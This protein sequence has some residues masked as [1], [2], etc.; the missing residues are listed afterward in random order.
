MGRPTGLRLGAGDILPRKHTE[1][2]VVPSALWCILRASDA[3]EVQRTR[4]TRACTEPYRGHLPECG[5]PSGNINNRKIGG[6]NQC[7]QG[8]NHDRCLDTAHRTHHWRSGVSVHSHPT[9]NRWFSKNDVRT[10]VLTVT[11]S[12][13]ASGPVHDWYTFVLSY[14]A[15]LVETYLKKF[16]VHPGQVVL[17]PFCGT[18]TT[19]VVA[20]GAGIPSIGIE[21]NPMAFFAS[22]VKVDWDISS[23]TLII[24]ARRIAKLAGV[25]LNGVGLGMGS[26]LPLFEASLEPVQSLSTF[27]AVEWQL[28]PE[29]AISPF[30]LHKLLVLRELLMQERSEDVHRHEL[31][32]LARTAVAVSNLKFGP[33][34]GLGKI[35]SDAPVV[36]FWLSAV[37]QMARDLNS[38]NCDNNVPSSVISG[39]A[40]NLHVLLG[41]HKINAIITSPPYP[42]EKDYTR[43]TR[44]ESVLLG[45]IQNRRELRSVKESLL[46]SNTRGVFKHDTD[47][48]IPLSIPDVDDLARVI[49]ARR[50]EL[51]KTSGFERLYS[52]LTRLYFGGMYRHLQELRAFL[53]PNARLAY[54]VGDQA[55]YFQVLIHTGQVVAK[56]AET[57][58]YQLESIDLF[59]A[60]AAT[61][62]RQPLR[63]EVVVLRWPG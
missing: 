11:P 27:S 20:K 32:A 61:A 23:D 62:T 58:G 28:L 57:L 25:R 17:D 55:S 34:V 36:E 30:P 43:T 1:R 33:E 10:M 2:L 6:A 12:A 22:S 7:P 41:G 24:H 38:S 9:E 59:R 44:L 35:K 15:D 52:R 19:L 46:R 21:S 39:D 48:N 50:I 31:L 49:E 60:R 45:F 56:L 18:G 63:E 47:D 51:G 37:E 4:N 29:N 26:G 3:A 16:G 13:V 42:N 8:S 14:P 40:R 54:V 53:V 5:L